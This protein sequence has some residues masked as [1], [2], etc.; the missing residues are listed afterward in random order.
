MTRKRLRNPALHAR[1]L[2]RKKREEDKNKSK[3]ENRKK[4]NKTEAF[5]LFFQAIVPF[6]KEIWTE[7]CIDRNTPVIGGRIVA[8]YD[9]LLKKVTQLYMMREMVLPE[10][11]LKIFSKSSELRLKKWLIRW[12]PVIDHIM[13]KVKEMVQTRSRRGPV[14]SN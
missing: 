6:I 8:E 2:R 3:G 13:K 5:H 1:K 10:D 4:N 7:R 9:A 11:E 14:L 12:R